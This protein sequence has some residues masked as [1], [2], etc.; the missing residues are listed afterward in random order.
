MSELNR[1][2]S[3]LAQQ[4][5][6]DAT[7]VLQAATIT[8]LPNKRG[9]YSVVVM[10]ILLLIG[11]VVGG[12]YWRQ[13]TVALAAITSIS[14]SPVTLPA[15]SSLPVIIAP[16]ETPPAKKVVLPPVVISVA[17]SS[18]LIDSEPVDLAAMP[19][20]E[21][22]IET[23][24][25]EQELASSYE[26]GYDSGYQQALIEQQQ[27]KNVAVELP[28]KVQSTVDLKPLPSRLSI[29]TVALTL[30]QLAEVEYHKAEKV[31]RQANS[32]QAIV[33]L[34]AALKYRPQWVAARQKLAALYYGRG[35]NRQAVAMLQQGL[36]QQPQ[37][38]EL[39]LTLAKL[40]VNEKQPQAALTVLEQPLKVDSVAFL[41]MRAALA[42]QL[43]NTALAL[44]SYQQ[45][46]QQ[47][48]TDGRWWLG[49]AIAQDR[50]QQPTS[51]LVSYRN[52]LM[53]GG[54]SVA[55]QQFIQ[56]RITALQPQR[57]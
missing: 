40:L 37:N 17:A 24:E 26:Q 47:D 50:S 52:G 14:S 39:R 5:P 33:H 43:N 22:A 56:Q 1:R 44:T 51:A 4:Q 53:H 27:V 3:A 45:L 9:N 32:R 49:L 34:E 54:I 6:D 35:D 10:I 28:K 18:P 8:P 15:K 2:L 31:L 38:T 42:Q 16:K 21:A 23:V 30:L 12:H 20:A 25:M 41:A 46:L 13:S 7:T 57:S 36:Q 11:L 48:A 55:S 19:V 29:Q